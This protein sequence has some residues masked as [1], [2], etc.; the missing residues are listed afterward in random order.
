MYGLW[1]RA[2]GTGRTPTDI[3]FAGLRLVLKDLCTGI[4]ATR[5]VGWYGRIRMLWQARPAVCACMLCLCFGKSANPWWRRITPSLMRRGHVRVMPLAFVALV[6]I[7]PIKLLEFVDAAAQTKLLSAAWQV[8]RTNEADAW[9]DTSG[10]TLNVTEPAQ[11]GQGLTGVLSSTA[12]LMVA[13][14]RTLDSTDVENELQKAF[15]EFRVLR[16][17][18]W[19]NGFLPSFVFSP[20]E[21]FTSPSNDTEGGIFEARVSP[22]S[23]LYLYIF[24][25]LF[26]MFLYMLFVFFV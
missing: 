15:A 12:S 21:A 9:H 18:Q 6:L 5:I 20:A 2:T 10:H 16:S 19:S 24:L 17:T 25:H 14:A 11:R 8:L 7:T 26:H 1:Y 13:M 3:L 23:F 4:L 22:G